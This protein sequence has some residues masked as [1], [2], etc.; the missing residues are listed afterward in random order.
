MKARDGVN[1]TLLFWAY[2]AKMEGYPS[3]GPQEPM[4]RGLCFLTWNA[5]KSSR[6]HKSIFISSKRLMNADGDG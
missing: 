6:G 4:Q 2:G 3:Y 1:T 5:S